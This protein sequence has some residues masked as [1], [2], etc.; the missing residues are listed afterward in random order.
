MIHF[1]Y[2]PLTFLTAAQLSATVITLPPATAT[3]I[4]NSSP[5]PLIT[6]YVS[7]TF[8]PT[9]LPL[10]AFSQGSG[11]SA[12]AVATGG[13]D[14]AVAA[15]ASYYSPDDNGLGG[16]S[17]QLTYFIEVLGPSLAVGVEVDLAGSISAGTGAIGS[18]EA[19]L[20]ISGPSD[21]IN[22]TLTSYPIAI[23]AQAGQS[24]SETVATA[25]L[26]QPGVVYQVALLA[27]ASA[28]CTG[29]GFPGCP[30]PASASAAVNPTFSIDPSTPNAS[31][32]SVAASANLASSAPEPAAWTLVAAALGL[33]RVARR[34]R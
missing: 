8:P 12:D 2:L 9:P 15:S 22:G 24:S 1:R 20:T 30:E 34:R 11:G 21:S 19:T 17:A 14:P 18:G 27:E 16:A 3:V 25:L 33:A 6:Q 29:I 31:D 28:R 32:Y 13:F 23:G 4:A 5:P 10:Q 7:V 26:L